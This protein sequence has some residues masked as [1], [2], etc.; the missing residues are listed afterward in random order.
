MTPLSATPIPG[1][2]HRNPSRDRT[3]GGAAIRD[4]SDWPK[5]LPEGWITGQ[6]P[7]VYVDHNDNVLIVNRGD[8]T[9]EE[10]RDLH[11]GAGGDDLQSGRAT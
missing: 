8:I 5:P 1:Y 10:A 3:R 9:D 6:L 11:P 2:H 7:C 4:R